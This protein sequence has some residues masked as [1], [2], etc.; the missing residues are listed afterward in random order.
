MGIV[1][2]ASLDADGWKLADADAYLAMGVGRFI[3]TLIFVMMFIDCGAFLG[4]EGDNRFGPEAV[5]VEFF[6]DK[7][8]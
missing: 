6:A 2:G 4:T 1:G 5:P 8:K 7:A 3:P